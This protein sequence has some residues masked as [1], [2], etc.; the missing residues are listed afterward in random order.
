[1]SGGVRRPRY[2]RNA[3]AVAYRL[4]ESMGNGRP[5]KCLLRAGGHRTGVVVRT[6]LD[7]A[8]GTPKGDR[9]GE[10]STVV[11]VFESGL[12]L[13]VDVIERVQVPVGETGAVFTDEWAG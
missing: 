3:S 8:R 13:A 7:P 5:V 9:P 12:E 2:R 4:Y 11:A 6:W 1:M 10:H